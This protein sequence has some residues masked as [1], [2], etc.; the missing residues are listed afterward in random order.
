MRKMILP[1]AIGFITGAVIT[2][3]AGI[4]IAP[5]MMITENVSSLSFDETVEALTEATEDAGWKIPK[6]HQID[7]SVSQD[8][9][10]VLPV[11][12]IEVCNPD[13]AGTILEDDD[14]RVVSSMMPCRIAVYERTDGTV[15]VS[16]MNTGLMSGMFGG[17]VKSTMADATD[18]TE[19]IIASV[20]N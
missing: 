8:G 1:A 10:D 14:A 19:R 4:S 3:V 16:R 11:T 6:I 12:V 2:V 18:D 5:G 9:Y 7:V 15:V 17:L 13:L 20:L